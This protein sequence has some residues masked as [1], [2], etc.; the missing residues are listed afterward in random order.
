M[1]VGGV[2]LNGQSAFYIVYPSQPNASCIKISTM[3]FGNNLIQRFPSPSG[4]NQGAPLTASEAE[5]S[6]S[7]P[8]GNMVQLY[9][10]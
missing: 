3:D 8:Y 7:N 1:N 4:N 6:C 5:S 2:N 10:K 9:F